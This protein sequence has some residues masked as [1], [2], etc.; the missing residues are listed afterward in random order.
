KSKKAFLL[1]II[2][3][4]LYMLIT[5]RI[6]GLVASIALITYVLITIATFKLLGATLTL[7]GIAGLIL[8]I[9]M[10][11]DANIIIFERIKEERRT[12]LNLISSVNNG[13]NRAFVTILDA[14]LTTL[15]A[16]IVLFWLGTGT[17][18]GFAVSLS[19][20]ILTSMFSALVVTKLLLLFTS[21]IAMNN[22]KFIFK[23][24]K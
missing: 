11:V 24:Q 23:G 19:I 14:N 3:I 16:A 13:F 18:K 15:S 5:Y 12:G 1:G 10:A 2:L 9:G 7:P 6:P 8:T 4:C 21:Q 17:I 20:G 22:D